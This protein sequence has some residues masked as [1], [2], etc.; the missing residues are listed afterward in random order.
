MISTHKV[1]VRFNSIVI[2]HRE[3]LISHY[4]NLLKFIFVSKYLILNIQQLH[5]ICFMFLN[6]GKV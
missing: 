1:T 3:N 5:A 6:S 4:H 2:N